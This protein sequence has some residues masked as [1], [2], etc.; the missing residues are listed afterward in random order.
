MTIRTAPFLALLALLAPIAAARAG[1]REERTLKL[2]PGGKLRVDTELGSVNVTGSARGDARVVV[3]SRRGDIED[4]L[5][6]TF[7]EKPGE[8]SVIG[9]KKHRDSWFSGWRD[10]VHFEI[11]VPSKTE[12]E[13]KTSGGSISLTGTGS[14][15]K[16]RTSGGSLSVRDLVGNLDAETSGGSIDLADIR[17][18]SRVGT[19]G[20]SI[21]ARGIQ[22][23]LAADTSGGSVEIRKV[24]GDIKAHTSGG[25][26]RISDAGGVLDA[27]TSGGGIEASFVRGNGRGGRLESSGG[28]VTVAVDPAVSLSIDASGDAVHTDLP[29]RVLGTVSRTHL[30]GELNKGGAP[31]R[32]ETTGGSVRIV[33]L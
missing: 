17:G 31:L 26:M 18:N 20:G 30:H 16:L 1:A 32:I 12:V 8:L 7:D 3:T 4:R 11:Q 22:G 13:V 28:S 23:S 6:L 29:L 5:V 9:K 10:N 14:P 24:T 21:E 19:S 25:S 15:A 33:P 2:A 27:E